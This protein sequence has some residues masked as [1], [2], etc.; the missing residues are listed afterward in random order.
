MTIKTIFTLFFASLTLSACA[1]ANKQTFEEKMQLREQRMEAAKHVFPNTTV[2][3]VQKSFVKVF[4]LL[5][6]GDTEFD[7]RGDSVLTSRWYTMYMIFSSL[8][9]RDYW[10]ITT[11]Q[12]GNNVAVT[13]AYDNE[14]TVGMFPSPIPLNYKTNIGYTGDIG[15]GATIDDYHLLFDRV[16]YILGN[17]TEW[18]LCSTY[19]AKKVERKPLALCDE[20]GLDDNTPQ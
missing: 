15:R 12:D 13:A 10:E 17:R 3:D 6:R 8:F 9:G 1:T 14:F 7:L 20:I 2:K 5:D 4:E 18:P 19:V 16:D 11:K